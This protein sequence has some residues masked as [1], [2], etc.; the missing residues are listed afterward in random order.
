MGIRVA[1]NLF[2]LP[3]PLDYSRLKS[4]DQVLILTITVGKVFFRD[5][6]LSVSFNLEASLGDGSHELVELCEELFL[7]VIRP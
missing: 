3:I 7:D 1:D 2:Y 6:K 5:V 4:L